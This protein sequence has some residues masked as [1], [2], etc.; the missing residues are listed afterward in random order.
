MVFSLL[1]ALVVTLG[2]CAHRHQGEHAQGERED[3]S[4]D[5]TGA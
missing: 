2:R 5:F 1:V 3:A 4:P